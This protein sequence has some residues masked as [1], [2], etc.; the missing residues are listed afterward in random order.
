MD[1]YWRGTIIGDTSLYPNSLLYQFI[2]LGKTVII[3]NKKL[4]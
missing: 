1:S 2:A 4:S 3:Q